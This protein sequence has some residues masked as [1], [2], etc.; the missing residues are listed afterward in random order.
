MTLGNNEKKMLSAM[1]T[2]MNHI[3]SLDE[4]LEVTKWEDQVHIAGS[5][6]AL[7][8][9][10]FV[11]IIET[12]RK[13]VSLGSEGDRAVKNVEQAQINTIPDVPKVPACPV[14]HVNRR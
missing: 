5:G 1:R 3:W 12:K 8:D 6:Q 14:I 4:L 13:I 7:M 10:E 9:E 2:K 11:E